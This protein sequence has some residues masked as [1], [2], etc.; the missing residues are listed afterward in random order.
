MGWKNNPELQESDLPSEVEQKQNKVFNDSHINENIKSKNK[1][2]EGNK[3]SVVHDIKTNHVK[4]HSKKEDRKKDR[5]LE[6]I[7]DQSQH[8]ELL[9][10]STRYLKE[11]QLTEETKAIQEDTKETESKVLRGHHSP[12]SS[13]TEKTSEKTVFGNLEDSN[14]KETNDQSEENRREIPERKTTNIHTGLNENKILDDTSLGPR[15]LNEVQLIQ[16]VNERL[17][18]TQERKSKVLR[19]HHSILSNL[20]ET[21]T[22]MLEKGDSN[23][24]EEKRKS[25]QNYP[26]E[27][28]EDNIIKGEDQFYPQQIRDIENLYF[29][30]LAQ[31]KIPMIKN[32]LPMSAPVQTPEPEVKTTVSRHPLKTPAMNSYKE[33]D[34]S[35]R[36]QHQYEKT[37]P[38]ISGKHLINKEKEETS[39]HVSNPLRGVYS[40]AKIIKDVEDDQDIRRNKERGRE[41]PHPFAGLRFKIP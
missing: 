23:F 16:D 37:L 21:N 4:E 19:G 13:L 17:E 1:I 41:S 15:F 32:P 22:E 35:M 2:N 12:L 29:K 30:K 8:E 11:A 6:S 40:S 38:N 28:K 3:S 24:E 7:R 39:L 10:G 31:S 27:I 26:N 33:I 36:G 14:Q 18:D 5:Y 20:Y 25:N 34:H 9:T